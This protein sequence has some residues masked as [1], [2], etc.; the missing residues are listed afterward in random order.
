MTNCPFES[1]DEIDDLNTVDEY[2]TARAAGLSEHD[3]LEAVLRY[4]RDNART[5]VQWNDSRQAGFTTGSPWL[6]LNPNYRQINVAVQDKDPDSVL[7]FYRALAAL[8]KNPAYQETIVYGSFEPVMTEM[9]NL[10]AFYRRSEKQTLLV[11]GNCQA[12]KRTITLPEDGFHR[13]LIN[14]YKE[15]CREGCKISLKPFQAV[16]LA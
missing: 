9:E 10:Y 16:I 5:P 15:L 8:R 1:I 13:I 4:S 11:L 14:N 3:A 7:N 6:R 2:N 12:A